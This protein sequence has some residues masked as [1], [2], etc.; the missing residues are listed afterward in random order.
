MGAVHGDRMNGATAS[1]TCSCGWCSVGTKEILYRQVH[2]GFPTTR[3]RPRVGD[4]YNAWAVTPTPRASRH[5]E[6]G[7]LFDGV[8]PAR[9]TASGWAFLELFPHV[10]PPGE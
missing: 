6:G 4:G 2:E 7:R 5:A 3:S 1:T 9:V 8:D 10:R